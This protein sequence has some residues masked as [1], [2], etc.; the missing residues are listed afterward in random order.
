[1][2]KVIHKLFWVWNYEKE[3]QWLNEMSKKGFALVRVGLC[4]YTFEVCHSAEYVIRLELLDALPSD[5]KSQSYIEFVEEMGAEYIGTIRRWVY[6]RK[7]VTNDTFDLY[8]DYP[9]RIN[10]MS[11]IAKF[12]G[13]LATL[14]IVIGSINLVL[15]FL[16]YSI[17]LNLITGIICISIAIM[18][19]LG[20]LR[21][22][23]KKQE[24]Y[25]NS[26]LYE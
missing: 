15:Y 9:S 6:F 3:E 16:L 12:C 26:R 20:L 1:M 19:I 5:P 22:E 7:K 4:T 23:L 17:V 21:I 2:T 24:L 11:R 18:L 10:H 14:N 13:L 8:S 25:T